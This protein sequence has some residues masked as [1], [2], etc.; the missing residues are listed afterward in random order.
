MVGSLLTRSATVM[1]GRWTSAW[2]LHL[3]AARPT[4]LGAS[5]M[6]RQRVEV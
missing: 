3:A 5:R 6:A 2:L 4:S 1:Y